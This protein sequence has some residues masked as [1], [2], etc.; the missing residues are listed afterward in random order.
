MPMYTERDLQ[1]AS[2]RVKKCAV[3]MA[4]VLAV[5]LA[6]YVL[7]LVKRLYG[8]SIAVALLMLIWTLFLGDLQLMPLKRYERF[9]RELDS[10]LRRQAECEILALEEE[11]QVQDGARVR[12]LHVRLCDGGSR[13]FYLNASKVDFLPETGG[14]CILVSCGRHVVDFIES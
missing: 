2:R 5:L 7:A 14:H 6:A 11:D 8:V 12:A 4:A 1:D 9:L 13:I 3:L 10:G